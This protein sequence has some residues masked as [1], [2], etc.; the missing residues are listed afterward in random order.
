M[1]DEQTIAAIARLITKAETEGADA[2]WTAHAIITRLRSAG[3]RPTQAAPA[4]DWQHRDA[5]PAP[6]TADY[7]AARPPSQP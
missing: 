1:T 3:W 7:L 6:P 4:P 2:T 5:A